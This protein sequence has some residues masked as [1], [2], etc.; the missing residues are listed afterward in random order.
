MSIR[1]ITYRL[2]PG[3]KARAR[4]LTCL[5]GACRWIWNEML[6]LQNDTYE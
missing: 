6:D 1:G 4:Q 3:T 5:A 2:I